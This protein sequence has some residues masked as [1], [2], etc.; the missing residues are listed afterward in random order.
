MNEVDYIGK[1]SISEAIKLSK[2]TKFIIFQQGATKGSTPVFRC[3]EPKSI[4]KAQRSFEDW[5]DSI[6]RVNQ[7]NNRAY[8]ILLFSAKTSEADIDDAENVDKPT[9]TDKIRFSFSLNPYNN[10]MN[11]FG[12]G[13]GGSIAEQIAKGIEDYKKDERLNRL[14]A[15]LRDLR[16]NGSGHEEEEEEH[17]NALDKVARVL[18][19]IRD[20]KLKAV[21][22]DKD[23][24]DPDNDDDADIQT[25]EDEAPKAD[26]K[27]EQR[28]A[29]LKIALQ[30]IKKRD[31]EW[32]GLY[33]MSELAKKNPTMFDSY[34][35]TLLKMKF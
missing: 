11:G 7:N 30:R 29:R 12:G 2:L 20:G 19:L 8:E 21:A 15:E 31:P 35:Q 25:E 6:L 18:T 22:G 16:E 10:M 1:K 24:P 32:K 28:V 27:K 26:S 17:E 3:T 33:K 4:E 5:A 9:K 13:G 23:V 14:E 34:M